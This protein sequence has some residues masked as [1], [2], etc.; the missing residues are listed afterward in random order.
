MGHRGSAMRQPDG[1][2]V[3]D[4]RDR[5]RTANEHLIT[6]RD[7]LAKDRNELQRRLAGARANIAHLN[8]R[9]VTELFPDGPGQKT[10]PLD[11]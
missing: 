5:L 7:Q 6:E 10:Q 3:Q 1:T 8:S 2:W 11:R 9:H 4:D